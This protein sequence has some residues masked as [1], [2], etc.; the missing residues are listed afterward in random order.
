MKFFALL[1]TALATYVKLLLP[2]DPDSPFGRMMLT[3]EGPKPVTTGYCGD[4]MVGDIK[5][6]GLNFSK[7]FFS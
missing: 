1:A 7:K 6:S 3:L 2:E 5:G 4:F